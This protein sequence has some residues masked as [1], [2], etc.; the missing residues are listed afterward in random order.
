MSNKR[1][2]QENKC[3]AGVAVEYC[4]TCTDDRYMS[5]CLRSYFWLFSAPYD[6]SSLSAFCHL[7]SEKT[8]CS[9]VCFGE[10]RGAVKKKKDA[11][12]VTTQD[13]GLS[14]GSGGPSQSS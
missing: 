6:I 9:A 11:H 2:P 7:K 1:K 10:A 3:L 12:G 13:G 4:M 5:G 14:A 8:A